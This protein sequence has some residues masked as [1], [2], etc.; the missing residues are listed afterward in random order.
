M[1]FADYST[2]NID[3][4]DLD[5]DGTEEKVLLFKDLASCGYDVKEQYVTAT[6]SFANQTE[7]IDVKLDAINEALTI[8]DD[9]RLYDVKL[10]KQ[11]FVIIPYN[12]TNYNFITSFK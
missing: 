9:S 11:L 12:I 7:L 3:S 5:G 1:E 6:T 10:G 8:V 4:V 2:V